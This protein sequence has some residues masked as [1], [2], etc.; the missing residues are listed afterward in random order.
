[1]GKALH[2]L[3]NSVFCGKFRT[4]N[5][6]KIR[7]MER[8]FLCAGI[9]TERKIGL[10]NSCGKN[11]VQKIESFPTHEN[12]NYLMPKMNSDKIQHFE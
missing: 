2:F 5:R 7:G 6:A 12:F 8:K 4:E 11:M 3:R 1:M 9:E 10:E